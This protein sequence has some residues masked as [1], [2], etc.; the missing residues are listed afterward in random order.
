MISKTLLAVHISNVFTFTLWPAFQYL[1]VF[2]LSEYQDIFYG[3]A[4]QKYRMGKI[5]QSFL[6]WQVWWRFY[7][8][9]VFSPIV[10]WEFIY[11]FI[12]PETNYKVIWDRWW[13]KLFFF[14][15]Y[16]FLHQD[17]ISLHA[18]KRCKQNDRHVIS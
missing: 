4:F 11:T 6:Y 8:K 16:S 2:N 3:V 7:V 9:H 18:A 10:K 13:C 17:L 1:V 15:F 14:H 5:I 12:L